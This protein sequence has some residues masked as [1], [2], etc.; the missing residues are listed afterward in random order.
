[1]RCLDS[2]GLSE[3]I[4][5]YTTPE[6]QCTVYHSFTSAVNT[7]RMAPIAMVVRRVVGNLRSDH[8]RTVLRWVRANHTVESY[9][10]IRSTVPELQSTP[11]QMCPFKRTHVLQRR[12]KSKS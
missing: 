3:Q 1:M 5:H 10:P 9:S 7:V 4:L 8:C 11:E 12:F 6:L 2:W